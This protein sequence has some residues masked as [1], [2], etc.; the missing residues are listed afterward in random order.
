MKRFFSKPL[1][2]NAI[3]FQ[4]TWFACVLGS[5]KGL[6][7]PA[8]LSCLALIIYQLQPNHRH[9]S[10]LKLVGLGI[11][12][13]LVTDTAWIQLEFMNFTEQSPFEEITPIWVIILWIAFALTVNHSLSW[14]NK[15]PVLPAAAGLVFAPFSYLAGLKLGAVEYLNDVVLVS[16]CLGITWAITMTILVQ[17][18]KIPSN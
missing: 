11:A 8:I 12:I 16:A 17:A 15:H 10:D 4:V 14:L 2:I 7:W 5:A 18:S 9:P 6:V 3:L 13:G 1:I